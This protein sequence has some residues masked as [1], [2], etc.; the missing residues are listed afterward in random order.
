MMACAHRGW[1]L[2]RY[3]MSSTQNHTPRAPT[4]WI[5]QFL[6]WSD[7]QARCAAKPTAQ[8]I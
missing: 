8:Q 5:E 1:K 7:A 4:A 6:G 3:I 2:A